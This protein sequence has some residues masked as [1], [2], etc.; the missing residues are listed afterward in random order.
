[1]PAHSNTRLQ[2]ASG[3]PLLA[4]PIRIFRPRRRRA[5]VCGGDQSQTQGLTRKAYF[6]HPL[7][8]GAARH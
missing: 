2:S 7:L 3:P 6:S 8:G 4:G 5:G 1:M